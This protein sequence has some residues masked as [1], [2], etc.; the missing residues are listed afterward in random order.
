MG[1]AQRRQL[2]ARFGEHYGQISK[3]DRARK[4]RIATEAAA[5]RNP[6]RDR[7]NREINAL[8]KLSKGSLDNIVPIVETRVKD[9]RY[10][11]TV[12]DI[13]KER[14]GNRHN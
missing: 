13:L 5:A 6:A 11:Q 9:G 3:A 7:A 14:M 8:L 1:K 4:A 12:L 2:Q 10:P